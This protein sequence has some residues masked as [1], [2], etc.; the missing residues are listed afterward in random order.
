MMGHSMDTIP[1]ECWLMTDTLA[2][3]ERLAR[4]MGW[5]PY[6]LSGRTY[7][8]MMPHP[9]DLHSIDQHIPRLPD[10][11][12]NDSDFGDLMRWWLGRGGVSISSTYHP[13]FGDSLIAAVWRGDGTEG[14]QERKST[15]DGFRAA[16]CDAILELEGEDER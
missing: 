5:R 16:V 7:W 12:T 1:V 11:Y 8:A 15:W 9:A 14:K 13:E 4:M 10:P 2:K 3:R 6:E